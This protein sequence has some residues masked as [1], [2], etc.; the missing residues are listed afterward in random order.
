MLKINTTTPA[1]V[2]LGALLCRAPGGF[3]ACSY[4][5][6]APE[7]ALHITGMIHFNINVSDFEPARAFYRAAGFIDEVGGFP[8][9]N[10]LEVSAGVGLSTLY[11]LRAEL[12]YLGRLPE[13]PIDLTAPTGRFID[14]VEWMEPA[15][16]DPPYQ[17]VDHLGFSYFSLAVEDPA[18][19]KTQLLG[20]GGTLVAEAPEGSPIMLQ[21]PDGTFLQLRAAGDAGTGIDYLNLNVS[22]LE[23]SRRF[24][25]MLGLEAVT[26]RDAAPPLPLLDELGLD[27]EAL[28]EAAV[29]E[30]RVDGARV[31][32][33]QWRGAETAERPY[34]PPL[35]HLGLQRINWAST[36]LRSDVDTLRKQGVN[37]V[38]DE[39]VPCC[40][41]DASTF[42]FIIF[43]DPDGIYNQLMGPLR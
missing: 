3:A 40:E 41:G 32:L 16:D 24:Y 34:A 43:E 30:H 5:D 17:T 10:T 7:D 35:N 42:G 22:D 38:S 36:D 26:P 12:V 33:N 23:C 6:I 1:L 27:P 14:L 39:I 29:L 18:S 19:V 28:V 2:L 37:F 31:R 20:K 9:T 8:E 25:A 21:D 11:R 13:A 4:E 15:R